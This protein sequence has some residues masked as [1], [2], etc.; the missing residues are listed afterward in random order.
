MV[1][2]EIL[3][4]QQG[5]SDVEFHVTIVLRLVHFLKILGVG[6]ESVRKRVALVALIILLL[7]GIKERL[8][9][10]SRL[11]L[12]CWGISLVLIIVLLIVAVVL[13]IT[14]IVAPSKELNKV[15]LT[16]CSPSSLQ[17]S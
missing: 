16:G 10:S 5:L 1:V 15:A 8:L 4:N 13:V 12:L 3:L 7:S 6:R 9:R 11:R 17:I 2:T 14:L